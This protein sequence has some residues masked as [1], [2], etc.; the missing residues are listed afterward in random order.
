M[1]RE[2]VMTGIGG[3]GIQLLAKLL[4]QAAIRERRNVMTF[5]L[6]MGTIRGGSS[7]STVVIGD[8]EI[9]APPIVPRIWAVLAMH[10]AGLPPLAAK[11]RP[12]GI[13][14]LN[15]GLVPDPSGWDGVRRLAVPATELAKSAGQAMGAGMV[16]L[17]ALAA[18][19]G[20]VR[21]G[22]LQEALADVVPAHRR[23]LAETNA[24]CL[25]L[26]GEYAEREAADT[27]LGAWAAP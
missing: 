2:V 19:T 22:S 5:G 25:A 26:G 11:I 14:V 6:F 3:Q 18:A 7:E 10:P 12:G 17:G 21:I 4:A 20:L 16:A 13:L 8:D 1:E 27:R 23:K 24:A 15:R 9:Q